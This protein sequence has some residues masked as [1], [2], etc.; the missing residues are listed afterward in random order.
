MSGLSASSFLNLEYPKQ[1]NGIISTF[2]FNRIIQ[3]I[4]RG[5]KSL[6]VAGLHLPA[7]S[8]ITTTG[9]SLPP[10]LGAGC[11]I[12][13]T[14]QSKTVGNGW[15]NV[16]GGGNTSAPTDWVTN[17]CNVQ[18][19]E[20]D[21]QGYSAVELTATGAAD[22]VSYI[23]R[24][25]T[26]SGYHYVME[27]EIKVNSLDF[28]PTF[29]CAI[30]S[31]GHQYNYP[32]PMDEVGVYKKFRVAFNGRAN[33][34]GTYYWGIQFGR[35]N[36]ATVAGHKITIRRV[37]TRSFRVRIG[38][39]E[40]TAVY[41]NPY[42][43]I[44]GLISGTVNYYNYPMIL[45]E[46]VDSEEDAYGLG[47][48]LAITNMGAM[49]EY[50]VWSRTF[51]QT[52]K[53]LRDNLGQKLL[54]HWQDYNS[55]AAIRYDED[56][57]KVEVLFN[58]NG[59]GGT[60]S[61]FIDAKIEEGDWFTFAIKWD[62]SDKYQVYWNGDLKL[63]VTG[64]YPTGDM[65]T[66]VSFGVHNHTNNTRVVLGPRFGASG[67]LSDTQ[68]KLLQAYTAPLLVNNTNYWKETVEIKH[69]G[70]DIPPNET[71][72]GLQYT[73]ANQ[74]D[75]GISGFDLLVA[76]SPGTAVAPVSKYGIGYEF[77]GTDQ[78]LYR[79]DNALELAGSMSAMV[80]FQCNDTTSEVPIASHGSWNPHNG[81]VTWSIVRKSSDD[82]GGISIFFHADGAGDGNLQEYRILLS[83]DTNLHTVWFVRDADTKTINFGVDGGAV[84]QGSY[85][86]NLNGTPQDVTVIGAK[87]DGSA[88]VNHGNFK[89]YELRLWNFA[90]FAS[91]LDD[92]S[93]SANTLFEQLEFFDE[94]A[95]Y[96]FGN[97]IDFE[98]EFTFPMVMLY[99]DGSKFKVS[100]NGSISDLSA[101][102]ESL[103]G[104]SGYVTNY[105]KFQFRPCE[106]DMNRCHYDFFGS[107]QTANRIQFD[108]LRTS[109]TYER[110]PGNDVLL[111]FGIY[112][113]L[114]P[115]HAEKN[116]AVNSFGESSP[117][118]TYW[119]M[120][121]RQKSNGDWY[122]WDG[123][124]ETETVLYETGNTVMNTDPDTPTRIQ[125]DLDFFS[126]FNR[127]ISF[128]I[129]DTQVVLKNFYRR[130]FLFGGAFFNA[131]G[132]T[133]HERI[134][135]RTI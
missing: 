126:N 20:E 14:Y 84:L 86:G 45:G 118:N 36:V 47:P 12:T 31:T 97:R 80:T 11:V 133:M 33:G 25:A 73:P 69:D 13:G 61:H 42:T 49:R 77:N 60:Q 26:Y 87:W 114:E 66:T 122:F 110:E 79:V 23:R 53:L 40:H 100:R 38:R 50:I 8:N 81:Q 113:L 128:K 132:R 104:I 93:D 129:N 21:S 27:F 7:H 56:V 48:A 94:H 96:F 5:E 101:F 68:I 17:G 16:W 111:S 106:T 103:I 3:A 9:Q 121:L 134:T 74:N 64:A 67:G 99:H 127:R 59:A 85:T 6:D 43:E 22:Y 78:Y 34:S 58:I 123:E 71:Q 62:V 19:V 70:F 89:I 108:Y 109:S 10:V 119:R 41:D 51:V 92:A 39:S 131:M 124:E 37:R 29:S 75:D 15:F 83:N 63:E 52:F 125:M 35:N 32:L 88:Y 4:A 117:S 82:G 54:F 72:H 55:R 130:E 1:Q 95:V 18:R 57:G 46:F 98:R 44:R 65:N 76:G 30:G 2:E 112:S 120:E 24:A 90:K 135:Q 107:H 28:T 102:D 116:N 91:E 115:T 105:S